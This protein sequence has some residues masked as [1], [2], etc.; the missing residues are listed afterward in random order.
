MKSDLISLKD[1]GIYKRFFVSGKVGRRDKVLIGLLRQEVPFK[2]IISF[3]FPGFCSEG[4]LSKDLK[5]SYST[6]HFHITK[7]L[8]KEVIKPAEG[9]NGRYFSNLKHKPFV[10]KKAVGREKF[11]N[12]K[13]YE[14]VEDLKRILITHK[15][16]LLDSKII[17]A[18]NDYN[19]EWNRIYKAKNF[20]KFF[21]F[22][23]AIDNLIE[24]LE[25]IGHLPFHL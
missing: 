12:I 7:L 18:Y 2:I 14:T 21:N 15:K 23:T 20:K 9:G 19:V 4:E 22:N 24:V 3:L 11:Y 13:D 8:E 17:A 6:V 5:L 1:D 16:N 10:V 25:E